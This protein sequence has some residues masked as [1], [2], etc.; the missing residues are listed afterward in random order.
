MAFKNRYND[1]SSLEITVKKDELLAIL[2]KK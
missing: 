2:K 1:D